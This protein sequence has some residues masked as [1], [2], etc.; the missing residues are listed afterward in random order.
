MPS[1]LYQC[2][3]TCAVGGYGGVALLAAPVSTLLD[4]PETSR[5]PPIEPERWFY[6]PATRDITPEVPATRESARSRR[7]PDGPVESGNT[8]AGFNL[9][10]FMTRILT[11][12]EPLSLRA[13]VFSY[14]YTTLTRLSG[15]SRVIDSSTSRAPVS[16]SHARTTTVWSSS[17]RASTTALP[18]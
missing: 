6:R 1:E 3:L 14:L 10:S 5:Y 18:V 8:A 12:F 16:A 9:R 13:V 15:P 17:S 11:S 2:D 7:F 4:G